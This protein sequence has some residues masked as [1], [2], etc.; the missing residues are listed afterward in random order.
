MQF[1]SLALLTAV[2]EGWRP[3]AEGNLPNPLPA[4]PAAMGLVRAVPQTPCSGVGTVRA[5]PSSPLPLGSQV[6]SE[7]DVIRRVGHTKRKR[8]HLVKGSQRV[9][10]CGMWTCGISTDPSLHATFDVGTE[11]WESCRNCERGAG[12]SRHGGGNDANL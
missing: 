2:R 11:N 9:S 8:V 1:A 5:A 4:T 7:P 12:R 3:V 6:I 10:L